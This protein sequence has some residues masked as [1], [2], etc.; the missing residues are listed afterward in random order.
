MNHQDLVHKA[1]SWLKNSR[2][3]GVVLWER[4]SSCSETP[5]AIGWNGGNSVLLEC[6]ASRQDFLC[7]KHKTHRENPK[8][9]MGR[10]RYYFTRSGLIDPAELEASGW[11]LLEW[12][13]KVFKVR[14]S[15]DFYPYSQISELRLLTSELRLIQMAQDGHAVS[16]SGRAEYALRGLPVRWKDDVDRERLAD[17]ERRQMREKGAEAPR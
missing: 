11:G 3:C 15:K 9:G 17:L 2:H 4:S 7:D 5:D 6:K 1:V 10:W 12:R 13:S 14:E 16:R 8:S